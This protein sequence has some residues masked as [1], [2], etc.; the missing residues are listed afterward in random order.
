MA[1]LVRHTPPILNMNMSYGLEE[2][3]QNV[4]PD[5][6]HQGT[7]KDTSRH[8]CGTDSDVKNDV[9]TRKRSSTDALLDEGG[10]PPKPV[11]KLPRK[12]AFIDIVTQGKRVH[13]SLSTSYS[14]MEKAR[15]SAPEECSFNGQLVVRRVVGVM[16]D[17]YLHATAFFYPIRRR[18]SQYD[19]GR[20]V[21]F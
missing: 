19:F 8:T 14:E 7:K 3:T 18:V 20:V 2:D 12:T 16:C 21:G 10:L 15:S 9:I 17:C 11:S 13:S 4:E 6:L 5:E 1:E